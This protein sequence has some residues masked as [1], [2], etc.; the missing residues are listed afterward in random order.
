ML[1]HE[2]LS[3]LLSTETEGQVMRSR[4]TKDGTIIEIDEATTATAGSKSISKY[5]DSDGLASSRNKI[6]DWETLQ[7]KEECKA[8]FEQIMTEI[9][10]R[11]QVTWIYVSSFALY[12]YY[13]LP[14]EY[15]NQF[16]DRMAAAGEDPSSRSDIAAQIRERVRGKLGNVRSSKLIV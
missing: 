7:F 12:I 3:M 4:T 14:C 8:L 2:K 11:K 16:L 5:R 9:D 1:G 13:N 6:L 15:F 10:E